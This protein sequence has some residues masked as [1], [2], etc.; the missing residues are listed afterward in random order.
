[1]FHLYHH[2]DLRSLADLL[3]VLRRRSNAAPLADET[4]LVPEPGIARWL[5]GYL[6]TGEGIAAGV[7]FPVPAR[8]FWRLIHNALPQAPDT[9]AYTRRRMRWHLY[10]L[11]PELAATTPRL[12]AYLAGEPS[13]VHRW[14]LANRLA[15]LF[16]GYLIHRGDLLAAWERGE[17]DADPPADWQ[18]P[19]WRALVARIGR[20]Q[21]HELLERF[22]AACRAAPG[23]GPG[24]GPGEPSGPGGQNE[25]DLSA[26]PA[27]LYC[28]GLGQLPADYLR[29][30]YALARHTD[31]HFL[32]PNPCAEYWGDI[33]RH[34]VSL[35]IDP[36]TA[37]LPD[38]E[39]LAVGHPLLAALGRPA[40]DFLRLL[41]SDELTGIHEPDLGEAMAYEPPI[42]KSL[43]HR[44]QAGIIRMEPHIDSDGG[45]GRLIGDPSLQIHACHGRLREVQV[46]HDQILDR[47]SRDPS[48]EPRH[49]VVLLAD[50]AA[51]APAIHAVF[52]GGGEGGDAGRIPYSVADCP[53]VA[54]HP[55]ARTFLTLLELPLSRWTAGEILALAAVPA[56]MRRFGLDEADLDHLRR[57]T[58]A[59]GVRWGFDGE[60]RRRFDAGGFEQNTW[61]FGLD[62]LL[63]GAVQADDGALTDGVAPWSDLEGGSATAVGKLWWLIETLRDHAEA[64]TTPTTPE[65]WQDR[66]HGAVAALFAAGPE[67]RREEQALAAIRDAVAALGEAGECLDAELLYWETVRDAVAAELAGPGERQPFLG[68]GVT[69]CGLVPLRA[70]PFR[71]VCLLGMDDGLF[72]RQE[73]HREINLIHHHPRLGDPSSRDDDRLLFLQSLMAAGDV[74]YLSYTGQD[75]RSGETVPPSPVVG[76]LLD[77]IHAHHGSD[78]DRD[79]FITQFVTHQP[80]QPFSRHYFEA[81]DDDPADAVTRPETAPETTRRRLFTFV[82]E[83]QPATEA[84][85]QPRHAPPPFVDG[86]PFDPPEPSPDPVIVELAELHRFFRHPARYFFQ[87]RAQLQLDRTE[88]EIPD[89]EPLALD[90]LAAWTL[91][92]ELFRHAREGEAALPTDAPPP[93]LKARGDLPPPPLDG[94]AYG[95]Q[96]MQVNALLPVWSQWQTV[97]SQLPPLELD[98]IVPGVWR[99]GDGAPP[100]SVRLVGRIE[101]PWGGGLRRMRPGSLKMKHRLSAW[102]D[103]LAAVAVGH[104]GALYLAGVDDK[105]VLQLRGTIERED[106][107]GELACLCRLHGEGVR[108]PLPFLPDLAGKYLDQTRHG[109]AP[110]T[111]DDAVAALNSTLTTT[112]R[113]RERAADD[114][115]FRLVLNSDSTIA[116]DADAPLGFPARAEAV[117]GPLHAALTEERAP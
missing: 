114:P 83:W 1:M 104:P 43:L 98:L 103:Y 18:A 111:P 21:R 99:R 92:E 56:V 91:R 80:M 77:F 12:A 41:Y 26:L 101:D 60:T 112:H 105:G 22:I 3:A 64:F 68:D 49:I 50:V 74:F 88:D 5:Q 79:T 28:F 48:L 96:A 9:T 82:A 15:D 67:D 14:Q 52:G 85:R 29:L 109:K 39:R 20:P 35:H 81:P 110:K 73:R 78:T 37:T 61:R 8:Y 30:L 115:Y 38:E 46:L 6:A 71:M 27:R 63:L 13:E 10:A 42:R 84:L 72:P 69:F 19:A 90:A 47:M 57:W 58:V 116:A 53:R 66:L 97:D 89:E 93:L 107:A 33:E 86:G 7:E 70:T 24:G 87:E 65:T 32:L 59:A 62:R 11:L 76:E 4:V 44:I 75:A 117:C 36:D 108:R 94:P 102:I 106:A 45:A 31:V 23:A 95:R 2:H 40:R 113:N 16:D 100:A 54:D 17:D 34:R 51:Y 25:F 55:V